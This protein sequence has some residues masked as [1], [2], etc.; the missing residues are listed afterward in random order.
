VLGLSL[1]VCV[2]VGLG[3]GRYN[4]ELDPGEVNLISNTTDEYLAV[5][6]HLLAVVR[7]C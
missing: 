7:A 4:L 5:T 6:A 3:G 1:C 2:C